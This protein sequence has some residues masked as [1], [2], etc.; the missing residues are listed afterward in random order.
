MFWLRV[1]AY[2]GLAGSGSQTG[3]L[4]LAGTESTRVGCPPR[5]PGGVYL[6]RRPDRVEYRGGRRLR[7]EGPPRR[8]ADEHGSLDVDVVADEGDRAVLEHGQVGRV[9]LEVLQA[10]QL[11]GSRAGDGAGGA[12]DEVDVACSA[13][14]ERALVGVALVATGVVRVGIPGRLVAPGPV[15]HAREGDARERRL[16]GRRRHGDPHVDGV[17]RLLDGRV[18]VVDLVHHPAQVER[19]LAQRTALLGV[20]ATLGIRAPAG[21]SRRQAGVVRLVVV[22]RVIQPAVVIDGNDPPL[23]ERELGHELV[24]ARERVAGVVGDGC[25]VEGYGRDLPAVTRIVVLV[26]RRGRRLHRDQAHH[27]LAVAVGSPLGPCHVRPALRAGRVDR[28]GDGG[29]GLR[30]ETQARRVLGLVEGRD[31]GEQARAGELAPLAEGAS[32]EDGVVLRRA[33]GGGRDREPAPGNVDVAGA[34]V[35]R[36]DD[37][38]AGLAGCVVQL[39]GRAPGLAAVERAGEHHVGPRV[40][41][42]ARPDH[43]D[44]A[45]QKGPLEE[46]LPGRAVR[47]GL[48]DRAGEGAGAR[49]VDRDPGL[50]RKVRAALV[51]DLGVDPLD[52]V[53]TEAGG[54]V[55]LVVEIDEPVQDHPAIARPALERDP[56]EV[57]HAVGPGS[58]HRV[59][60]GVVEHLAAGTAHRGV[61]A[62]PGGVLRVPRHQVALPGLAAV[63]R[64]EDALP[65]VGRHLGGVRHDRDV[66]RPVVVRA[67]EQVLRVRRGHRDGWLV[68][69][70]QE[71][72]ATRP[73]DAGHH[74]DALSGNLAPC[75]VWKRERDGECNGPAEIGVSRR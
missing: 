12:V 10:E 60:A 56:R 44:G 50:V 4:V 71:G 26:V 48:L 14:R 47:V 59:G 18:G 15:R 75:C 53:G 5:L 58:H 74:V 54:A 9:H 65:G 22:P 40:A 13:E 29:Q 69:A 73:L 46:L 63:V 8:R 30:P 39:E 64:L 35:D 34:G 55:L 27:D 7:V 62:V 17:A 38:L 37:S 36:G 32:G 51:D 67:G 20:P 3:T 28:G 16:G 11:A 66:D 49:D 2:L 61:L 6:V 1:P 72:I 41:V 42:D 70:L 45:S 57:E 52:R 24:T 21:P 33:R 25:G 31:G 19:A 43:V 23:R 68:L